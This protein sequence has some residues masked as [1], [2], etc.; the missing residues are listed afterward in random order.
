MLLSVLD[1]QTI[2]LS[3]QRKI[4][5]MLKYLSNLRIRRFCGTIYSFSCTEMKRIICKAVDRVCISYVWSIVSDLIFDRL[6]RLKKMQQEFVIFI[7]CI[8]FCNELNLN[9][10]CYSKLNYLSTDML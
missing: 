2:N 7:E 5:E 4:A 6:Q 3:L 1:A 10:N 8:I 9:Q